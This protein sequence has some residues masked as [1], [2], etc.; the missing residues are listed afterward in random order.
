MVRPT[1]ARARRLTDA[2]GR[3]LGPIAS[4]SRS[5]DE[6]EDVAGARLAGLGE[7]ELVAIL[8]EVARVLLEVARG[9]AI[10]EH[11]V[12]D[13]RRAHPIEL[14]CETDAR[15][16]VRVEVRDPQIGRAHV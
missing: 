12:A 16:R 3:R 9:D 4:C 5:R 6:L 2:G 10:P 1:P 8:G 13:A 14:P 7:V 11:G 15:V